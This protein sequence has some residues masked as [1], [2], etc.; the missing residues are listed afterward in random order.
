MQSGSGLDSVIRDS[1]KTLIV[2]IMGPVLS[3]NQPEGH[4]QKVNLTQCA[5]FKFGVINE[6][7]QYNDE[8]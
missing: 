3:R 7:S 2:N 5:H 4:F 6:L 1:R 8:A